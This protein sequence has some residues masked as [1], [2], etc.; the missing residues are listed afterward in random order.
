MCSFSNGNVPRFVHICVVVAMLLCAFSIPIEITIFRF[1]DVEFVHSLKFLLP[2]LKF[3]K[4]YSN[5]FFYLIRNNKSQ[6]N[7][8]ALNTSTVF[9]RLHGSCLFWGFWQYIK[10]LVFFRAH[11]SLCIKSFI[12]FNKSALELL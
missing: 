2:F 10:Y 12:Y 6:A 3:D 7:K 9:V 8:E 1:F 4:F 5:I 11:W